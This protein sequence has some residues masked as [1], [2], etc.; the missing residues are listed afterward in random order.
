MGIYTSSKFYVAEDLISSRVFI[1][2]SISVDFTEDIIKNDENKA[3]FCS[4]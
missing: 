1:S 4:F 3:C 2:Q